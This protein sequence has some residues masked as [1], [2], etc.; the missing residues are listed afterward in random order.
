MNGHAPPT[1]QPL[2][3]H[4]AAAGGLGGQGTLSDPQ[5]SM[6]GGAELLGGAQQHAGVVQAVGCW[7]RVGRLSQRA[8]WML[9]PCLAAVAVPSSRLE[10][11]PNLLYRY[12]TRLLN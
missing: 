3:G 12:S 7:A 9:L 10:V 2:H 5:P 6:A 8:W 11:A 1:L 4:V